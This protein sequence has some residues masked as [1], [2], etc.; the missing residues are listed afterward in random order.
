MATLTID[1]PKV[2]NALDSDTRVEM[3]AALEEI[4]ERE[5]VRVLVV[6]GAGDRAFS[7]GQDLNETRSFEGGQEAED[8][9]EE[10]DRLY[11]K[12]LG[13]DVPVIAKLNGS[14][15]GSAFQVALLCDFR[16]A[17]GEAEVGMTEI[18][19][20]IPCILGSWIIRNVAGWVPAAELTLTGKMIE[21]DEA[22]DLG[23]VN[24][25]VPD[26]ELDT[27]VADL[28]STLA[29]KPPNSL[30]WQKRWLQELRFDRGLREVSERGG[31]I[32]AEVYDSGE[33]EE[34]MGK[35]LDGE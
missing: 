8:W 33:P 25:V 21:A 19:I 18:D 1:R 3:I 20:G 14:T 12:L 15:A 24:E 4:E 31:E 23:L 5:S 28:A 27:A 35:F 26:D 22:S 34:Y 16:I 11:E 13:V 7:A 30:M 29:E 6:T 32:H 9:V 10:F 2:L 17:S